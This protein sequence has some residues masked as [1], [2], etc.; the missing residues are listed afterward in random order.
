VE[1]VCLP[2]APTPCRPPLPPL[3]PYLQ[4]RVYAIGDTHVLPLAWRWV[5]LDGRPHVV[6]PLV[7]GG[8]RAS[9]LKPGATFFP[10]AQFKRQLQSG[11]TH[12]H[13]QRRVGPAHA[14][15]VGCAL[16]GWRTCVYLCDVVCAMVHRGAGVC[17][18][19]YVF[20]WV[21]WG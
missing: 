8:L 7:A 3:P 21:G 13:R 10:L 11:A 19:A 17:A 12:A 18:L 1:R 4:D 14:H 15:W 16:H 5:L 6:V 20:S 9:H 2:D